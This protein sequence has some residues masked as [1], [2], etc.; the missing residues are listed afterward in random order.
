MH[1][2]THPS[3]P[4]VF[5]VVQMYHNLGIHSCV[6]G[7]TNNAASNNLTRVLWAPVGRIL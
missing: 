4:G 5:P 1:V 7:I 3:G 2:D 6:D